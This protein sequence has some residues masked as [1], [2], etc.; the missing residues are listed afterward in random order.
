[1]KKGI[2]KIAYIDSFYNKSVSSGWDSYYDITFSC[3]DLSAMDN[4]IENFD[5][6]FEIAE[7]DIGTMYPVLSRNREKAKKVME[8]KDD[9][10]STEGDFYELIDLYDFILQNKD[11]YE[12]EAQALLDS[13]DEA[14]VYNRSSSPKMKGLTFYSPF[15]YEINSDYY[16]ISFSDSYSD[17]I[18]SFAKE[19]ESGDSDTVWFFKSLQPSVEVSD[20]FYVSMQLSEEQANDFSYGEY[21]IF[22]K[23]HNIVNNDGSTH[24]LNDDEYSF[25][26]NGFGASLNNKTLEVKIPNKGCYISTDDG[27]LLCP[28]YAEKDADRI[29]NY[30]Q[31]GLIY[32][33]AMEGE[34]EEDE[35]DSLVN[36]VE[37]MKME[38]GRLYLDITGDEVKIG[39]C[40]VI[41]NGIFQRLTLPIDFYNEIQFTTFV[42]KL[43]FD[44]NSN[45]LPFNKWESVQNK[46]LT[47]SHSTKELSMKMKPLDENA[48]YY[49]M[50]VAHDIYGNKNCS[51]II[52]LNI[53]K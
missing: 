26:S 28:V 35:L 31:V 16:G 15:N 11:D 8:S 29:K 4:V 12:K 53:S 44:E 17:Y 5:A 39:N 34:T 6:F 47:H 42:K 22:S 52:P 19:Q 14:I 7:E 25:V 1:M 37:N 48:D 23:P 33:P 45:L 2:F 46:M 51:E 32:V 38:V 20:E 40:Y 27:D 50:L 49:V 36:A 9:I 24:T 3:I 41:K 13:L 43:S 18:K 30:T 21:Y 10:F